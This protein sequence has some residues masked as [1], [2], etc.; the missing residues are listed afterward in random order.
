MKTSGS[1]PPS[2]FIWRRLH[3]LMGLWIVL[4]LIEHLLLNSQAALLFGENGSGFVEGVNSIKA[5]PYLPAIEI[6]LLGVPFLIHG[7]WGIKYL[8]T[9]KFNSFG[10]SGSTPYLPE[11]ARNLAYTWQRITSWVL[12]VGI[13]A[14]VIHMR[15]IEYPEQ[16]Q[17]GKEHYYFVRLNLDD[18]LY[19]V[20]ARLGAKLYNQQQIQLLKGFPDLSKEPISTGSWHHFLRG[21]FQKKMHPA[22]SLSDGEKLVQEQEKAQSEMW[23]KSLRKRPLGQGQVIA[24]TQDFGT[25]ELL[26][27]RDTF[28][29]PIMIA[30]YSLLVLAACFHGFNGLW[31]F[32]ITWGVTLTQASQRVMLKISTGLMV[33]IA[34]L[35]LAAIWGTYWINLKQ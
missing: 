17:K 35:G 33:L 2:P 27:V 23:L 7:V 21:I 6:F 12:V 11:Y 30:L 20:A 8:L 10:N 4:F 29:M 14:H 25:A 31:T 9:G 15:F 26:M 13:V 1:A 22:P 19:T 34:F 18:G 5:L 28:K 32:L 16:S 3:S 24:V